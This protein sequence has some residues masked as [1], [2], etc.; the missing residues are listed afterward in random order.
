MMKILMALL[1]ANII[2]SALLLWKV[3]SLVNEVHSVRETV[4]YSLAIAKA[5]TNPIVGG[6]ADKA[7]FV[8]SAITKAAEHWKDWRQRT[9]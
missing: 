7:V 8:K 6:A 9:Q 5:V 1:C 2:V 3:S 4:S